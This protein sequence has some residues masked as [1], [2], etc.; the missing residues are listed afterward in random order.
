MSIRLISVRIIRN[1][2]RYNEQSGG[3]SGRVNI[4]LIE[5]YSPPALSS[6][7]RKNRRVVAAAST[8]NVVRIRIDR[9]RILIFLVA[10]ANLYGIVVTIAII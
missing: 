8:F 5:Q 6:A 7:P 4:E 9:I 3:I 1:N 10:R 2:W